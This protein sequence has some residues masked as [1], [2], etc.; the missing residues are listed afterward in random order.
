[1]KILI[2]FLN[3]VLLT[4][5]FGILLNRIISLLYFIKVILYIGLNWFI[6]TIKPII[7]FQSTNEK[8]CHYPLEYLDPYKSGVV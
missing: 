7:K 4:K 8:N 6:K 2:I 5:E 1:M 3:F